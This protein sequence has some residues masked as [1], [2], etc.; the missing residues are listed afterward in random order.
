MA[1]TTS[2]STKHSELLHK[3]TDLNEKAKYLEHQNS[4]HHKGY[5]T[6]LNRAIEPALEHLNSSM[7]G[8]D[9]GC[10]YAPTIS[11]LLRKRG[12]GCENY[13]PIFFQSSWRKRIILF[14]QSKCLNIS[15]T[16]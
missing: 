1:N 14:F 15:F 4:I 3:I 12:I 6:F 5:V 13:D 10:G 16:P 8:L 9:Y 11:E 2:V 7:I